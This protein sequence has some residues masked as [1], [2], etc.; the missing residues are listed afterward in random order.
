MHQ[1][2]NPMA[3]A[4]LDAAE[5]L[6][7][8]VKHP[9]TFTTTSGV[10]ATT[11]GVYLPDFGAPA[12]ALLLCRFDP[13]ELQALAEDTDFFE[14]ALNPESYE[15]YRRDLYIDTL[16]DWGW[17]GARSSQPSWFTGAYWGH[18]GA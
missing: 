10:S 1:E 6:G 18:G 15:P 4:W 8:R 5:D 9:F 13:H 14:S 11:I 3:R 16:N 7:I 17:F 2:T 12:G